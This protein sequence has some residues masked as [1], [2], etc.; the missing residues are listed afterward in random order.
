MVHNILKNTKIEDNKCVAVWG[1]DILAT[2][3]T[4]QEY[5]KILKKKVLLIPTSSFHL[6]LNL[7]LNIVINDETE[8]YSDIYDLTKESCMFIKSQDDK[9]V[10]SLDIDELSKIP[11]DFFNQFELIIF[12][13]NFTFPVNLLKITKKNKHTSLIPEQE[14]IF[15]NANSLGGSIINGHEISIKENKDDKKNLPVQAVRALMEQDEI[16]INIIF[17]E[18]DS[19]FKENEIT[20]ISKELVN[21]GINKV[22]YYLDNQCH[23][24]GKR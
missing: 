2:V 14:Y 7:D 5:F 11:I 6:Y 13:N 24:I 9:K 15:I 20:A 19:C 4:M 21:A 8:S 16:P 12:I 23:F 1:A 22:Y 10:S 3:T 18:V 17:L